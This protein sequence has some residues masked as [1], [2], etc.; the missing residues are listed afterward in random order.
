M[1]TQAAFPGSHDR[2]QQILSGKRIVPPYGMADGMP[3]ALGRSWVE[4]A[5]GNR[6]ELAGTDEIQMAP[7]DAIT[8]ETPGGGG[9]GQPGNPQGDSTSQADRDN[10][11]ITEIALLR[12]LS[13][14]LT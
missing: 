7:G 12:S 1:H 6:V 13:G 9:F 14:D 11:E 5:G 4:R 3:G 10:R 8:I 2:W